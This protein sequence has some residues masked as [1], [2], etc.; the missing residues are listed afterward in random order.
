MTAD[1]LWLVLGLSLLMV[2]G[3]TVVRGATGLA[4]DLGVSPLVMRPCRISIAPYPSSPT[5]P[6]PT[7]RSATIFCRKLYR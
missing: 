5:S 7:S 6:T 3:E 4:R 1:L 2:G